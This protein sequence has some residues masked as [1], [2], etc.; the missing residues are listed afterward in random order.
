[1]QRFIVVY[2]LAYVPAILGFVW[3]FPASLQHLH[4][5]LWPRS[6]QLNVEYSVK[7]HGIRQS[8]YCFRMLMDSV[9]RV[10]VHCR[11]VSLGVLC[12]CEALACVLS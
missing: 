2:I 11:A 4:F 10:P 3:S 7:E 12:R 1:M 8:I 9:T 5:A 6:G